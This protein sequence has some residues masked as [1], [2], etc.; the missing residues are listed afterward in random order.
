MLVVACAPTLASPTPAADTI[1]YV[2]LGD[3]YTI[4]TGVEESV[5]WP[6]QLVDRLAAEVDL[7]LIANLGV[8]G[9]T[10]AQL[11]DRE[12]PQMDALDPAFVTVLI[13][14]NDVV[15]GVRAETYRVNMSEIFDFL[16]ERL[17]A[18]RIVVVSTPDYTRTPQGAAFGDPFQQRAAIAQFNGI[19]RE[20]AEARGIT[21]VGISSVADQADRDPFL[22]AGDGLHPSGT[23]YSRWVDLIAPVVEDLLAP[24]P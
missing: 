2:A 23:Q 6:N 8:N 12:L 24:G 13:G 4:G 10:S 22:V 9:Y 11:I 17:P 3:S 1:R 5:R 15:R 7:E 20:L 19:E 18:D 14:V 21:F 16:L